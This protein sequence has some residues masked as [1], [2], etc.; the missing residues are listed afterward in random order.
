MK[1][2]NKIIAFFLAVLLCGLVGCE[3]AYKSSEQ[4]SSDTDNDVQSTQVSFPVE[5]KYSDEQLALMFTNAKVMEGGKIPSERSRVAEF[6]PDWA[7]SHV[8]YLVEFKGKLYAMWNSG[9]VNEDDLGQRVMF[10]CSDDFYNW[11]KPI[12]LVDTQMGVYSEAI[13]GTAGFYVSGDTLYAY[14]SKTELRAEVLRENGT[15]RPENDATPEDVLSTQG[16]CFSTT[17][18]I[19]WT[20][21]VKYNSFSTTQNAVTGANGR[22]FIFIGASCRYNDE[23]SPVAWNISGADTS[24]ITETTGFCEACGLITPDNIVHMLVR[25]DSGYLYHSASYDNGETWGTLCKTD[26]AV[27]SSMANA[28]QLPDG[29]YYIICNSKELNTWDRLPL[30]MYTSKDG[31]NYDTR[32]IIRN[33]TDYKMQKAGIAKGGYFAYPTTLIYGNYMY[34]IY[35]MQKEVIEVTRIDL[36]KIIDF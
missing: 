14:Y 5:K 15:L 24:L 16:Y 11:S 8:P 28:G 32:Y 29:T 7:F 25:N 36:T 3:S 4:D 31:Y 10:S 6:D 2:V 33:E 30:Y 9:R 34:I 22:E 18:G 35:S 21:P 26:F 27:E 20:E 12:P 23:H 19:N 1:T 17:D 13:L